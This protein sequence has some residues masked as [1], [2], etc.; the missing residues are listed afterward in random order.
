MNRL[1]T[2]RYALVIWPHPEGIGCI[3]LD[4]LPAA[5]AR[6]ALIIGRED[7]ILEHSEMPV[8]SNPRRHDEDGA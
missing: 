2:A 7:A 6:G 1:I 4:A 5:V 8:Q 3:T